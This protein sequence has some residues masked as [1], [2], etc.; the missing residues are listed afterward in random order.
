MPASPRSTPLPFSATNVLRCFLSGMESPEPACS[1]PHL[2]VRTHMTATRFSSLMRR[3]RHQ[4]TS[5][6]CGFR[7]DFCDDLGSGVQSQNWTERRGTANDETRWTNE[8]MCPTSAPCHRA[9]LSC[10]HVRTAQISPNLLVDRCWKKFHTTID[11]WLPL[12]RI[13]RKE[14][15]WVEHA[16]CACLTCL[17]VYVCASVCSRVCLD[18]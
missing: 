2:G 12:S 3:W 14:Y 13:L 17:H 10:W 16:Q 4:T 6:T 1:S 5:L 9:L 11:S 8:L 7:G 18:S 15:R